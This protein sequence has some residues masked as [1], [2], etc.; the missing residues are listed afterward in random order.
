MNLIIYHKDGTS[1]QCT[2]ITTLHIL[3]GVATPIPAKIAG[4]VL[5]LR[6]QGHFLLTTTALK[7]RRFADNANLH[8]LDC[9]AA[10]AGGVFIV[11]VPRCGSFLPAAPPSPPNTDGCTQAGRGWWDTTAVPRTGTRQPYIFWICI[12]HRGRSVLP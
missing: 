12:V 7:K 9:A 6:A 4:Q 3:V 2:V 10:S 8:R 1:K 11:P 5:R